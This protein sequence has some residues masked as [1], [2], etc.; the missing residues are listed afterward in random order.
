ML[1]VL[2]GCKL[3]RSKLIDLTSD[4]I[5]RREDHWAIVDLVGKA[6][7]IR[8][9]PMPDWVKEALDNWLGAADR[10]EGKLFRCVCRNGIAWGSEVTEKVIWHIVKEYARQLGISQLAPRSLKK[11]VRRSN[12]GRSIDRRDV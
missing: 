6:A 11:G 3:R 2:L 8:T 7:H 10:R 9:V 4:H 5:Q 12:R 1:A